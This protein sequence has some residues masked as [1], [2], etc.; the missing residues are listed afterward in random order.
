MP[1]NRV[2]DNPVDRQSLGD[3]VYQRL[4][5]ELCD[6]RYAS[7]EELNEVALA[8]H[9]K[10]SRTPVRDAL[11]RL[12]AERLV[13]NVRNRRTTV[14]HPSQKEVE[15]GKGKAWG[16]GKGEGLKRVYNHKNTAKR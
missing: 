4:I 12:A 11:Q 6:G 8:D 1:D 2:L 15:E 5:R 3:Q 14:I 9:Y 16:R 13:V 7:G 10:V